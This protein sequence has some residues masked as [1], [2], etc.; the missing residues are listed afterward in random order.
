[1][2][3]AVDEARVTGPGRFQDP[4]FTEDAIRAEHGA[5]ERKSYVVSGTD[6]AEPAVVTDGA[7][8]LPHYLSADEL[9]F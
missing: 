8:K 1:V 9:P 6:I 5:K 3:K 2:G 7:V 4:P